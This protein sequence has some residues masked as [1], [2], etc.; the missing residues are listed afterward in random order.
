VAIEVTDDGPGSLNG[1]DGHGLIGMRERAELFG[2]ELPRGQ[3]AGR[4]LRRFGP[5]RSGSCSRTPRSSSCS[6]P[7]APP[8][9]ASR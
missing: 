1:S 5:V 8:A 2:G 4:R 7:F 9:T 3:R 6:L